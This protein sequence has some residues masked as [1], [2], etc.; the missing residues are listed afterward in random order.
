MSKE[1][2]QKVV[3]MRFDNRNFERNVQTSL[4]TLDKLKQKLNFKGA[5]KS[6]QSIDSASKK[7]NMSQLGNSVDAVGIKFNAMHTIADQAL[8]NITNSAMAA[9]KRII[10][11]LT[12]DPVKSGFKEYELKMDSVK[13]IMASTGEELE[14]VNK[15]LEE[16]NEYSDQTI[17]SFSDMTQNIG[18]FTNAGVK[19]EDAV[20]AIK[21]ISNEAAVSGANAN[22]ASRAMYNFSQALSAGHVKLIDWKSIELANMATKEFKEQLIQ[23]AVEVGT[24][25]TA[26]DGMYKTLKGNTLNATKNFNDTLKDEWM[27][28]DVLIKTLGK[29]ADETTEIGKKA[30]SAAKDVTKF[31]QMLDVLKETAQSGWARTWEIIFGDLNAA[32]AFFTPLTEFFSKIIKG[33]S[34]FR[35]NLLEG[36]LSSP[37]AS[38]SKKLENLT[39]V[40]TTASA[41]LQN[42]GDVV[43]RVI[44]GDYGNGNPRFEQLTTEG[45][46][47]MHIQNL[48]NEKLG[49]SHRYAVEYAEAQ[50]EVAAQTM[51][52][53][54]AQLKEIGLTNEEIKA[55]RDLEAQSKKTGVPIQDLIKNMEQLDGRTMLLRSFGNIGSGLLGIFKAMKDAWV[56]IFPPPTSQQLYNL[57]SALH[58]FT[59][60]LRLTDAA[61]GKLNVTGDKLM[62][63]FKGIFAAFD[64][65]ITIIGGP[66]KFAL[67]LLC[68]LLGM[69]NIDILSV[70]A[71]TGDVIVAFRNWLFENNK[72][73]QGIL[74]LYDNLKKLVNFIL[75]IPIVQKVIERIKKAFV[76]TFEIGN[77]FII[78]L[79][80][81]IKSGEITLK[82]IVSNLGKTILNTIKAILGIHSPSTEMFEVGGNIIQGLVNGLK[83]GFGL[84]WDV[85]KSLGE[86]F[87]SLDWGKVVAIASI[88]AVGLV[89]K[90]LFDI[91][92]TFAEG[93]QGINNIL[94]GAGKV[95]S[96]FSLVLK[97]VALY[98][99][100]QALETIAKAVMTLVIAII[101]L[102]FFDSGKL[103]QAVGIIATLAAVLAGLTFVISK[104]TIGG[105]KDV[106]KFSGTLIALSVSLTIMVNVMRKIAAMSSGDLLKGGAVLAGLVLMLGL[107][108]AG[109]TAFKDG[110]ITKVSLTLISLTITLAAM[111]GL[112]G[113]ISF[114]E[115]STIKKGLGVLGILML[116]LTTFI[117]GI[118]MFGGRVVVKVALT[119]T[120]LSLSLMILVGLMALISFMEPDTITKGLTVLGLLTTFL[121]GFVIG[122]NALI[123][124][125]DAVKVGGTLFAVSSALLI[126][127]LTMGLLSVM[128]AQTLVKGITIV[129]VL[130]S[131][132]FAFVYGINKLVKAKQVAQ[133]GATLMA[134]AGAIAILSLT[135]A[136]L[137]LLS[138]SGIAKGLV[139]IAGIGAILAG[140][141]YV[142]K[143]SK[144]C[145]KNLTMLVAAI[146]VIA[147]AIGI[148]SFI[149]P[150]KLAAATIAMST[151]MAVFALVIKASSYAA[152]SKDATKNLAVMVV[153][154]GMI[155]GV[156][157]VTAQLPTD[158][159][160]AATASLS[161]LLTTLAGAMFVISKSDK[162]TKDALKSMAGMIAVIVLLTGC[163]FLLSLVNCDSLIEKVASITTLMVSS[164]AVMKL[165]STIPVAAAIQGAVGLGAFLGIFTAVLAVLGAIN[166][167]PGFSWLINEGGKVLVQLGT[168]LG[169]FVGS[170]VGGFLAGATSTLGEVAD[171]LSNFMSRLQ[172]FIDGSKNVSPDIM[173]GVKSLAEVILM[174]TGAAILDAVAGW[175]TGGSSMAKFAND[176]IPF[177]DAF[178]EFSNRTK[179]LSEED[180]RKASLVAGVLKEVA[181]AADAIPNSGGLA[182]VFA[183][184]NDIDDF[185]EM[186]QSFG[187]S[188]AKYSV[189]LLGVNEDGLK[190]NNAVIACMK[191][192]TEMAK[193]I[194]NSGGVWDFYLGNNDIDK[195]GAKLVSFGAAFALYTMQLSLV[196]TDGI[197]HN[198]AVTKCMTSITEMARGIPKSG[199]IWDFFAGSNDIDDFGIKLV[200]FGA[201]FALYSQQLA[202]VNPIVLLIND[203]VVDCMLG[204]TDMAKNI[205]RSG[206]I[207]EVFTGNNDIDKFGKQLALFGVGFR[208]YSWELAMVNPIALLI[209]DAV[210]KCMYGLTDMAKQ[211]PRSGGVWE[212]FT[213]NKNIDKFG[214][215]LALFGTGFRNYSWAIA[216]VNPAGLLNTPIVADAAVKLAEFARLIPKSGGFWSMFDG[217]NSMDKFGRDLA[218]FGGSMVTFSDEI[219]GITY[220]AVSRTESVADII[221]KIAS[222][223]KTVKGMSID[224]VST[225][226]ASAISGVALM[227]KAFEDVDI[228]RMDGIAEAV[229][230]ASES[231]LPLTEFAKAMQGYSDNVNRINLTRT[232]SI[233]KQ[234]VDLCS[235]AIDVDDI[236]IYGVRKLNDA[237][238]ELVPVMTSF[239]T[240]L[241]GIDTGNIDAKTGSFSALITAIASIPSDIIT[242]VTDFDTSLENLEGIMSTIDDHGDYDVTT[243]TECLPAIGQAMRDYCTSLVGLDV[244]AAVSGIEAVQKLV[245]AL[246]DGTGDE[247]ATA[248]PVL[249]GED[250]ISPIQKMQEQLA[251][252]ADKVPSDETIKK[253]STM[254]TA[255]SEITKEA[256]IMGNNPEFDLIY[257]VSRLT[258]MTDGLAELFT[259]VNALYTSIDQDWSKANIDEVGDYTEFSNGIKALGG[260]LTELLNQ[261]NGYGAKAQDVAEYLPVMETVNARLKEV[262]ECIRTAFEISDGEAEVPTFSDFLSG[263]ATDGVDTFKTTFISELS[264]ATTETGE[265]SI[266]A[267]YGSLLVDP[268]DSVTYDVDIEDSIKTLGKFIV[269]GVVQ[270]IEDNKQTAIDKAKEL[271]KDIEEA[272]AGALGVQSPSRV[273]MAIGKYVSEGLAIGIDDNTYVAE[274]ASANMSNGILTAVQEFFKINSPSLVMNEQGRYIV[275]GIADGIEAD[276]SAEEAAE[277]K[278]E[279]IANAF[280][281]A[282]DRYSLYANI[283]NSEIELWK[284][285]DGRYASEPEVAAKEYEYLVRNV[286]NM[287]N[288]QKLAH[289]KWQQ[290]K[291][292]FGAGSDKEKESWNEYYAAQKETA[293]LQ[294]QILDYEEEQLKKNTPELSRAIEIR[295]ANHNLWLSTKGKLATIEERTGRAIAVS[296]ENIANLNVQ[297]EEAQAY[298]AYCINNYAATSEK[299]YEAY[300]NVT[301]IEQQIADQQ[302]QIF[303]TRK[304][305]I[306]SSISALEDAMNADKS[307]YEYWVEVNKHNKDVTDL[308]RDDEYIKSLKAN[309]D[310]L[311]NIVIDRYKLMM[312]A[313]DEHGYESPEY[314]QALT[315]W[316]N[317]RTAEEANKNQIIEAQI[318]SEKREHDKLVTMYDIASSNADLEYQLWEKTTGRKLT[319]TEKDI[320]KLSTLSN[321]MLAQSNL[322]NIARSDWEKAVND[323]GKMSNEAQ[324]AYGAFLQKQLDV[325][326]IQNEITTINEKTVERQKI[327]K[328]EYKDYIEKYKKFYE[329]NGMTMDEL[330]KDAELVSGYDPNN[331]VAD[332]VAKTN[333]AF[334]T[335]ETNSEYNEL[336]D[337][338]TS[339]GTSYVDAVTEGMSG[340]VSSIVTTVITIGQDCVTTLRSKYKDWKD[341]GSYVVEGFVSGILSRQLYVESA[342]SR[343]SNIAT[344]R[345]T[346]NLGI[347]SPSRVFKQFGIYTMEGF[348]NGLISGATIVDGAMESVSSNAIN[349]LRDAIRHISDF[350]DSDM[351]VQ[352]TI[353]PV[354]DLSNIRSE[355]ARL[356]SM[357]STSN[358]MDI[359]A[360]MSSHRDGT[361]Q[362]GEGNIDNSQSFN[363]VQNNYS[364]KA[365]SRSDIYRQTKNQFAA[366]KGALKR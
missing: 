197:Q 91:V 9:G 71:S 48:V 257:N 317:A 331:T 52:L 44:R 269:D 232:E 199:G 352:P 154:I 356:N 32:K 75:A 150:A 77:N 96:S 88:V 293:D 120:A 157:Y 146:A 148:L 249:P 297:L 159:A 160:L 216:A 50:G 307:Y 110:V 177:A 223:Y 234:L 210:V 244:N 279:N 231:V 53:T 106:I 31:S 233:T 175:I 350:I 326:E 227:C 60:K 79:I 278:A 83:F 117:G 298:H 195:F 59:A 327:A 33:F 273:F 163:L 20:L 129:A 61:T 14:T 309:T 314:D 15:Y 174:L 206:G 102:T 275:Q 302:Q 318:E 90:K 36:A 51:E 322:L 68:K 103:W 104:A 274:N 323:Y 333:K 82:D 40:S 118:T 162:I 266:A 306:D 173:K 21:G 283:N 263:L 218:E 194:P 99:S 112:I 291:D 295:E 196:S 127:T 289:D 365:L 353:R 344:N 364:P 18:K 143:Y 240:S 19:L 164:A 301:D 287:Q 341:A 332:M 11:S 339:M 330:R 328:T 17:Y 151:V 354:L 121:G 359:N 168:I 94:T 171:N 100:A 351:D 220:T 6:L 125:E 30:F 284:V 3:E 28:T 158:K 123:K 226:Y 166:Q 63:T 308:Q 182:G 34:D 321:Q 357:F 101:A 26:S 66:I 346:T 172:P 312:I 138:L 201:A 285:K 262:L 43:N 211:V 316:N 362:N 345:L 258:D 337:N 167:I 228:S 319:G 93:I 235:V 355:T 325:A 252:A 193:G 208:L 296:E 334:D 13:T 70:T 76:E 243:F 187:G 141:I 292:E 25:S 245:T 37:F 207:F 347:N 109:I 137:S 237:L 147:V 320:A 58:K 300:K 35:N 190:H 221:T 49:D 304:D 259:S 342:V 2:D 105:T 176:L 73:A 16:L 212:I 29:Y 204:L 140:L 7:V 205:P 1:I 277:K 265:G 241:T 133:V 238:Q 124:R 113:L 247:G 67:K 41:K 139:A 78:G 56:A 366:M 229:K 180:V 203:A 250:T 145:K 132:L 343:I 24:L 236:N 111:I 84:V 215:Q 267:A 170:V 360:R 276:M 299:V 119:L 311:H 87:R 183:G 69:A 358:A 74:F 254:L 315:A 22:E 131:F 225:M 264:A 281:K 5:E 336:I 290:M 202:N 45:Y 10:S 185:G 64:I 217:N 363:F 114:M 116:F 39:N 86:M 115:P 181:K 214:K 134:L 348:A 272:S 65:V 261:L 230:S 85:V 98:V 213:G 142:T 340:N 136:I 8:R 303:D 222:A 23:T 251:A 38:L 329:L 57:I 128:S 80:N 27:T 107:F 192:I 122:I 313:A 153:A 253:V 209:N 305:G 152:T 130:S 161:I 219:S 144:N 255:L 189:A 92:S 248:T 310:E 246:F 256:V 239:N 349:G 191:G 361:F 54:D 184:E 135:L 270:G 282:M 72:L 294:S 271:A 62:R 280:Q 179:K 155:A 97:S 156:L 4:S 186:L 188:F 47:W 165:V 46:N 288:K 178:V 81:G 169:E 89:V 126:L 55:Y 268:I 149:D 324:E 286:E 242:I 260:V 95:L 335:L 42:F 224:N 338:F 200:R 108:I 12:I 198:D